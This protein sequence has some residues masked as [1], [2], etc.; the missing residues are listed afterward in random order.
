[1]APTG[2]HNIAKMYSTTTGNGTLT[3]TTAAPLSNT[4]QGFSA[5]AMFAV[6]S[7]NNAVIGFD[8]WATNNLIRIDK[9]HVSIA[10]IGDV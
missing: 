1:M 10:R 9:A 3:L 7:T 8:F 5:S 2:R 6:P 4:N